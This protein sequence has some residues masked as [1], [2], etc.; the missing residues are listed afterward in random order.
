MRGLL[1][2]EAS[3]TKVASILIE[4]RIF[5]WLKNVLVFLPLIF[6][7]RFFQT[8]DL[9]ETT[10]AFASLC[11]ASS[12]VYIVNDIFDLE[13]D[14]AHEKKKY[15]PLASNKINLVEISLVGFALITASLTLAYFINF[16][17]LGIII[18]FIVINF[19][20]SKIIKNIPILDILVVS[21]LYLVR[22][23]SGGV[24]LNIPISGWLLMTTLFAS[25]FLIIGKRRA[26]FI[27]NQGRTHCRKVLEEY[28]EEFLNGALLISLTLLIFSYALYSINNHDS[29]FSFSIIIVLYGSLRYL[30]LAFVKKMGEEPDKMVFKDFPLFVSGA[31]W[32]FWVFIS[33][34][35][36][37]FNIF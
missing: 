6:S 10:I 37:S 20:Y 21:L 1:I 27:S 18:A 24:I 33:L 19:F 31:V 26:E 4:M 29:F 30:Y 23:Y 8:T 25:L 15:R 22:V 2:R 3:D 16:N 14:R 35:F 36:N 5:Q 9:I 34:Y 11:F 13:S 32:L 17:F 28:N 7:L 12:F